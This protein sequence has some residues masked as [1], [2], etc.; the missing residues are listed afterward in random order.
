[1]LRI[2]IYTGLKFVFCKYRFASTQRPTLDESELS[3]LLSKKRNYVHTVALIGCSLASVVA[4]VIILLLIPVHGNS[5][6]VHVWSENVCTT[7]ACDRQARFL[8]ETMQPSADTC[9]E[10]SILMCG[11]WTHDHAVATDVDAL[12]RESA[13]QQ[14]ARFLRNHTG[15]FDATREARRM[16]H[17]CLEQQ[18]DQKAHRA[19]LRTFRDFLRDRGLPW[20]NK[21]TGE[22]HPFDVLLDLSIN[23]R[24]DLWFGVRLRRNG[25]RRIQFKETPVALSTMLR[26]R[27]CRRASKPWPRNISCLNPRLKRLRITLLAKVEEWAP[28]V[29]SSQWLAFLRKHLGETLNVH[30]YTE[31]LIDS[32]EHFTVIG[33]LL[34]KFGAN[35]LLNVIGWWMVRLFAD[36]GALAVDNDDHA[37]AFSPV[38]CQRRVD[39]CYGPAVT[40][41]MVQQYWTPEHA[42]AVNDI[43]T[44]VQHEAFIL[45]QR[46]SWMGAVSKKQVIRKLHALKLNFWPHSSDE[47][48]ME[49]AYSGFPEREPLY[50]EHWLK[51]KEAMRSLLGT[52]AGELLDRIPTAA[53]D[54]LIEYDYWGN[55]VAVSM[56][57][58]QEPVF[59]RSFPQTI[60]YAGLGTMFAS[61]LVQAFDARGIMLE[62]AE[63]QRPLLDNSTREVLLKRLA[64]SDPASELA[65]ASFFKAAWRS[66]SAPRG[67][68]VNGVARPADQVFF[69]A[70]CRLLCGSADAQRFCSGG[71]PQIDAFAR[72]YGCPQQQAKNEETSC[73]FFA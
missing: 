27:T 61:A 65:A 24:I 50:I 47:L 58:L 25:L 34:N 20:P 41:E 38:A 51:A 54:A 16:L 8:H 2:I 73:L 9:R 42:K 11:R 64:C 23:W 30:A 70:Q 28:A 67:L 52:E 40:A 10:F 59:S 39:A 29:T 36:L 17:S 46:L 31:I 48:L 35:E 33:G 43:F 13:L 22:R 14:D 32:L 56:A 44:A 45:V 4:C 57:T 60:N 69:M 19:A 49:G 26:A 68:T 63:D 21:P 1:M 71:L 15:R 53:W 37:Q 18:S 5:P 55:A 12:L 66:P 7:R 62:H 6:E 72:A 3:H